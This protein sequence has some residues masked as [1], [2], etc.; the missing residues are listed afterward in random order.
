[1]ENISTVDLNVLE[2][3]SIKYVVSRFK[4][5]SFNMFFQLVQGLFAESVH[6]TDNSSFVLQWNFSGH[7]TV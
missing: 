7:Y 3:K 1:M 4:L 2:L 5:R 6:T